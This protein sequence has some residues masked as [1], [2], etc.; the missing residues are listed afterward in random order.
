[1]GTF[2]NLGVKVRLLSNLESLAPLS[3]YFKYTDNGFEPQ[4]RVSSPSKASGR[5]D[6][7]TDGRQASSL[8]PPASSL[9]PPA[10]SLQPVG[11]TRR[12][13]SLLPRSVYFRGI[14]QRI[15]FCIMYVKNWGGQKASPVFNPLYHFFNTSQLK[16]S[17]NCNC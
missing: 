14:H 8:Q 16:L 13:S 17:I 1:M 2:D 12:T 7:R 9:Q 4:N 6:G 3:V 10:S 15:S 11:E 5:T